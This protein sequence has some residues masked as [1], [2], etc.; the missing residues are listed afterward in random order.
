MSEHSQDKRKYRLESLDALRGLAVVF[1]ALDHTRDFFL[2][3]SKSDPVPDSDFAVFATRWV[4]H[5]CAPAFVILA[6]ISVGLMLKRKSESQLTRLLISRGIWLIAVDCVLI[7]TALTFSP[8]GYESPLGN[9]AL[10]GSVVILLQV[11][12]VIG[13][14]MLVLAAASRLGKQTCLWIGLITVCLH[15]LLDLIWPESEIFEIHWPVWVA[16]HTQ[17]SLVL[18]PFVA[19]FLYPLIPWLGV[20][21]FGF[22]ISSLFEQSEEIQRRFLIRAGIWMI[23]VF[24]LLRWV[25][26]YGDPNPWQL[27]I[28][29]PIHTMKEFAYL[30]KYPPSLLF[31][32]VTIGLSSLFAGSVGRLPRQIL[33]RVFKLSFL[34]VQVG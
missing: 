34:P 12:W 25:N 4:T 31:L 10:S 11:L 29:K 13:A 16:L 26:L 24:F 21:L 3:G 14:G 15:N 19:L 33:E 30:K 5:F 23:A 2:V 17:I 28:D 20:M 6:G 9:E 22:G 7:S 32:L 27:Q 8:C 1:M 18:G